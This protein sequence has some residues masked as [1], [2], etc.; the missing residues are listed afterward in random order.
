MAIT[1]LVIAM[2]VPITAPGIV[3]T[4]HQPYRGSGDDICAA[5]VRHA[6]SI[7]ATVKIASTPLTR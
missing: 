7:S 6:A 5:A 3:A 2:S 1:I 4:Y